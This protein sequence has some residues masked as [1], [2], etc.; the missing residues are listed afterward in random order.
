MRY[1]RGSISPDTI[2]KMLIINLG[3]IGDILLS[4]P[5]LRAL[6]GRYADASISLL[7]VG[8]VYEAAKGISY[9]DEIFTLDIPPTFGGILADLRTLSRLK[10]R[11]FD[12]A[13][14]MR[15]LV[16]APSA[17]KM[18]ILLDIIKPRIRAGR[19]TAGRGGFF[20]VKIEETDLGDKYEME[21]D[22]DTARALGAETADRS[23]NFDIAEGDMARV[24]AFLKGGGISSDE[25]IV[26][27][28][29]GGRPSHKW[30]VENFIKTIKGINKRA[31]CKFVITGEGRDR[32]IADEIEKKSGVKI[33]NTAGSM[34]LKS[35]GAL[36]KMAGL[37]I[38][39]D[40]GPMHIA[41][42][43]KTPM[44]AI[45]GPGYLKRYDPRNISDKAVVLRGE[46]PPCAPCN[47]VRCE[48]L[49][50]LK[51]VSTEDVIGASLGFL[52]RFKK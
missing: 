3:G 23:L 21:Y 45:F 14:N 4:V 30:P 10:A 15:T 46:A 37:F 7:V 25:V 13:V 22:I 40:T 44:V 29:L 5:A 17:L 28:N 6:R 42:I 12:L 19:D 41:A 16:S 27:V 11:R 31:K 24:R 47:R 9:I 48:K 34:D 26:A 36:I 50:C 38:S 49:S 43:M 1:G 32:V 39:N 20:D 35:L 33:L 52:E 51:K 18:K 2:K 8:R